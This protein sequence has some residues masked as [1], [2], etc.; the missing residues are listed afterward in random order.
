MVNRAK[1]TKPAVAKTVASTGHTKLKQALALRDF[2]EEQLG[3]RLRDVLRHLNDLE[4][5]HGAQEAFIDGHYLSGLKA[6]APQTYW[7]K[8]DD[9]D[10]MV[11][12]ICRTV[13]KQTLREGKKKAGGKKIPRCV[14]GAKRGATKN[15]DLFFRTCSTLSDFVWL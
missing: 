12:N 6:D 15:E 9:L 5:R 8:L 7:V 2:L 13:I 11:K 4:C 1:S 10:L 14:T 3:L